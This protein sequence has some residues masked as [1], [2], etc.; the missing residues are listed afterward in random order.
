MTAATAT[1]TIGRASGSDRLGERDF[2]RL[3]RFIQQYS[4]IRMPAS[5]I[6]MLEGRLR[7]RVRAT[8]TAS[9]A[10]YCRY[11]FDQDGLES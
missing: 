8:G 9:L 4:G 5:K 11:L 6:T 7:A 3:A 2:Q 10:G 1:R